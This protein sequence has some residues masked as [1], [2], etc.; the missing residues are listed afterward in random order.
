M[1]KLSRSRSSFSRRNQASWK[2]T[3]SSRVPEGLK[4]LKVPHHALACSGLLRILVGFE[5]LL[6]GRSVWG[7]VWIVEGIW[8][9]DKEDAGSS[10]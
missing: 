9:G 6:M 4:L 7:C 10:T 1:L 2:R 8:A 3:S 5:L